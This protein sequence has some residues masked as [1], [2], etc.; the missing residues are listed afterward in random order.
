MTLVDHPLDLTRRSRRPRHHDGRDPHAEAVDKF[1]ARLSRTG[2][3][4]IVSADRGPARTRLLDRAMAA[5]ERSAFRV[6]RTAGLEFE[7]ALPYAALNQ[8][9]LPFLEHLRVLPAA[10][11][12]DL[13]VAL[14]LA[15]G[16]VSGDVVAPAALTLL[17]E[18]TREQPALLVLD[19][20]HRAD[21]DSVAVLEF[22]APRLSVLTRAGLLAAGFGPAPGF[23]TLV[24]PAQPHREAD[25]LLRRV[26]R[27]P[28]ETRR[29]LLELALSR[30]RTG[31]GESLR[32]ARM[33][34]LIT[35]DEPAGTVSFADAMTATVVLQAS[36]SE[37]RR[38]AHRRLADRP[39][40]DVA[41][42][43]HH[44]D[45]ATV[46]PDEE[47]AGLLEG[48]GRAA[49][50]TGDAVTAA[51]ALVRAAYASVAP[52]ERSRRLAEAARV[53]AQIPGAGAEVSGLLAE[54]RLTDPAVVE[55]LAAVLARANV[56]LNG[57]GDVR[58]AHRLLVAGIEEGD[59]RGE[60]GPALAEAVQNLLLVCVVGHDR[61][62][63]D[64]FDDILARHTDD[65]PRE[66]VGAATTLARPGTAS[67]AVLGRLDDA[68][69]NLN[70]ESSPNTVFRVS[71]SAYGVDRLSGCC[72]ALRRVVAGTDPEKAGTAVLTGMMMLAY[73][74][75]RAG[76]W[77]LARQEAGEGVRLSRKIRMPLQEL[78]GRYVQAIIHAATGEY[79][80]LRVLDAQAFQWGVPR[81]VNSVRAH[82][83]HATGLGALS[84]G[85]YEEAYATLRPVA[86]PFDPHDRY[87]P[88]MLLDFV[89]ACMSTLR[90]DEARAH[91]AAAADAGVPR[92]SPR[93]AFIHAGVSAMVAS[94][95]AADAL[96]T[97]ALSDGLVEAGTFHRARIELS[98]GRWLRRQRRPR[99]A[100]RLL[101]EAQSTFQ[102]LGA[103]PWAN[104]AG[105]EL[106]ATAG[107]RSG[108]AGKLTPQE[109]VVAELA[110]AGLTNKQIGER[111]QV[112]HRT[113]GSHLA[114]VFPKLGVTSRAALRGALEAANRPDPD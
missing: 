56:L 85:D 33:A 69:R 92:L 23:R 51:A 48:A 64:Q 67:P 97:A 14:G 10:Q 99:D 89:E 57:I 49:L 38:Q 73:E 72:D 24:L 55:S 91:V 50:A 76:R 54:A 106:D 29:A 81:G 32:L 1:V 70:D 39:D 114:R 82:M 40:T 77:Q 105:A 13:S 110:A 3:A 16:I 63:W 58:G 66:L 68:I 94:D 61:T 101:R 37:E 87:A 93:N 5:A 113:I 28:V 88:W 42:R 47:V 20:L 8:L 108:E 35:V 103:V 19:G 11:R 78:P 98:Y 74:D 52:G 100:R 107:T 7:A 26:G 71:A 111:L 36:T 80:E 22:L 90:V 83:G 31:F 62:M 46:G 6:V 41:A 18:V 30:T 25:D 59:R 75:M 84:R 9:L 96:Y 104:R 95:D 12:A 60:R 15:N 86:A 109:Q 17:A 27:L 79:E 21:P 53:K 65:L 44:L 43:T 2:D 112:S 4:M 34:G 45:Q 102:R